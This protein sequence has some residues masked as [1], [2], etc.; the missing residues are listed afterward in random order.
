MAFKVDAV[1]WAEG[2][3]RHDRHGL[4]DLENIL[5]RS[6]R[7]N[8]ARLR[9]GL[10]RGPRDKL[11]F[12]LF[13]TLVTG[14]LWPLPLFSSGKHW[15]TGNYNDY[16]ALSAHRWSALC[17]AAGVIVLVVIFI[18]WWRLGTPRL[19]DTPP[20]IAGTAYSVCAIVILY[21]AYGRSETL[22]GSYFW[23][24]TPVWATLILSVV[25]LAYQFKS[26]P[27]PVDGRFN[28]ALLA[29]EDRVWLLE[30]R[31]AALRVLAEH[32]LLDHETPLDELNARPLGELH[33]STEVTHGQQR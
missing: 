20:V 5:L 9:K 32:G 4:A 31:A 1:T 33:L 27:N 6:R 17:F 2:V 8:V 14:P 16:D 29:D 21:R 13:L 3:T 30:E 28:V 10:H 12:A 24:L 25:T 19:R 7:E 15:R 18:R 26:L 22:G 11:L 23:Y